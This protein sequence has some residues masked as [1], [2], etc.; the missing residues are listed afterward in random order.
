MSQ[1]GG[2][3]ALK[4]SRKCK[5]ISRNFQ[6]T[7]VSTKHF[8]LAI[9]CGIFFGTIGIE[10]MGSKQKLKP[11]MSRQVCD[12]TCDGNY[13]YQWY[14][15]TQ[16]AHGFIPAGCAKA[17]SIVA[18]MR[19]IR[20]HFGARNGLKVFLLVVLRPAVEMPLS[21]DQISAVKNGAAII[22][23]QTENPKKA[24]SKAWERF[25]K[26]KHATTIA[27]AMGNSAN[28]QDISGDFERGYMKIV[29]TGDETMTSSTKRSAPEGTP[30]G[31]P[32][33][34]HAR[35]KLQPTQ[36][37]P[38]VLVPEVLDPI[39]KMEMSA[40]TIAALRSMMR[41]DFR[42]GMAEMET[43]LAGKIESSVDEFRK[44]IASERDARQHLEQ[45]I[46]HL[47]V[48]HLDSNMLIPM[49]KPWTNQW[50]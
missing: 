34:A 20:S 48:K 12:A 37:V 44:E 40:A 24:G 9:V 31:T 22:S 27:E 46:A 2:Q 41:E 17:R 43:M 30:E 23:I 21:E 25:E 14:R 1:N 15:Q 35:A 19:S 45:R 16:Y 32:G 26:Y 38:Q 18:I 10:Q 8:D 42:H 7:L 13:D 3:T 47:E 4:S 50:L 36:L 5:K 28:W 29:D 33:E 39:H 49:Q 6:E 11:A